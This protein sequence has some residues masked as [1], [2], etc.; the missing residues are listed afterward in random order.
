MAVLHPPTSVA[1]SPSRPAATAHTLNYR[2]IDPSSGTSSSGSFDLSNLDAVIS[3]TPAELITVDG[4][5]H[6]VPD[7]ISSVSCGVYWHTDGGTS[8]IYHGSS[9]L[10]TCI[11]SGGTWRQL[12][13]TGSFVIDDS[14]YG[15]FF[16]PDFY[17]TLSPQS[18][19]GQIRFYLV[20]GEPPAE[21]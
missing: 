2:I 17:T 4:Q 16:T 21:V 12:I 19:G 14:L 5:G 13:I 15:S 6:F 8:A 3:E 20:D 11:Q 1:Q 18:F 7:Q 10:A 9:T